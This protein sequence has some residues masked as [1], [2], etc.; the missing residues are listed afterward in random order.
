MQ[1]FLEKELAQ[2]GDQELKQAFD[3]QFL[4]DNDQEDDFKKVEEEVMV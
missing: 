1:S 3:L 2:E 4:V